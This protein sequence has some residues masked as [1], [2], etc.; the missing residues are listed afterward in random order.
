MRK[1]KQKNEKM[2]LG[3]NEILVKKNGKRVRKRQRNR[4]RKRCTQ[5]KTKH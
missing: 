4:N 5:E 1:K 3:E 2:N